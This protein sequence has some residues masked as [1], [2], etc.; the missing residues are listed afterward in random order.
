[1]RKLQ[2]GIEL[3]VISSAKFG[4]STRR[5][6]NSA[7]ACRQPTNR[8]AFSQKVYLPCMQHC[9]VCAAFTLAPARGRGHVSGGFPLQVLFV[10]IS[11]ESDRAERPRLQRPSYRGPPATC[12][13]LPQDRPPPVSR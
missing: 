13:A 3:I 4:G 1:M 8:S 12:F 2:A 10:V 7:R 6:G 5:R 9:A 11:C